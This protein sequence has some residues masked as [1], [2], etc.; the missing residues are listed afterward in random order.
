MA[1]AIVKKK[2]TA[3]AAAT[4]RGLSMGPGTFEVP[5]ELFQTNRVRLSERLRGLTVGNAI[6]V[7][8]GGSELPFYDT[9]TTYHVFRQVRL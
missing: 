4:T 2:A 6:V 1:A 3:K 8:Q 9:D 7:L 5:L